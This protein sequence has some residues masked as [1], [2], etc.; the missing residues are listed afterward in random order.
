MEYQR[1][2]YDEY[3]IM[4][5]TSFLKRLSNKKDLSQAA[6]SEDSLSSLLMGLSLRGASATQ[7]KA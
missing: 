3:R 7:N 6:S 4:K 2:S 1:T 5:T